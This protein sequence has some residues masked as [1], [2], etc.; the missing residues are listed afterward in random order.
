MISVIVPTYC[1][2]ACLPGCLAALMPQAHR[3]GAEVLVVDGGS[4]DGTQSTARA[5]ED[6]RLL[7]ATR[8]R[9][10]QLNV[11]ARA[12]RGSLLV[13]LS[14]DTLLPAGALERLA[15][16]DREGQVRAGG[17]RQRFNTSRRFLR[18][19]SRLHNLRARLT[20][21]FY[22]DQAPFLRRELFEELGGF[23]E[24]VDLEDV[25]FGTRLRRRVRP[26][27]LELTVTTSSRRF[28]RHGDLRATLD[29][30]ALLLGWVVLR[31]VG[32]SR[33]FFTPVR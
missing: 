15:A 10:S 11:G 18:G 22:G 28:D 16:I 23:R 26:R 9:A 7:T 6:V 13:F 4:D 5:T 25:E 1:E 24:G 33:I 8:G 17:F 29:A 3:V 32:R 14:A 2:Q 19:I 27:Q 21:V 30:A 20:G 31:R 12:A